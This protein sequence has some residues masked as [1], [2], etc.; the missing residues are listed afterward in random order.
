MI[1]HDLVAVKNKWENFVSKH[2][3]DMF[4]INILLIR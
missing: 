2:L 1:Y 4:P 3:T